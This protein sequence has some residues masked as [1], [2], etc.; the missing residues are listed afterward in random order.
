MR[1][2][3]TPDGV[4]RIADVHRNKVVISDA[5]KDE[6]LDVFETAGYTDRASRFSSDGTQFAVCSTRGDVQIWK[7]GTP[8]A[9]AYHFLDLKVPLIQ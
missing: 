4:L 9:V 1:L 8:S 6:Q 2:A 3:Y 5:S 7:A